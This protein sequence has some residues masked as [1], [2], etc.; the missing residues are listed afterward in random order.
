MRLPLRDPQLHLRFFH[1][2]RHVDPQNL[3]DLPHRRSTAGKGPGG[4]SDDGGTA[5]ARSGDGCRIGN[6]GVGRSNPGLLPRLLDRTCLLNGL[7]AKRPISERVEVAQRAHDRVDVS[8]RVDL[9][10]HRRAPHETARNHLVHVPGT[11]LLDEFGDELELLVGRAAPE[12]LCL[13]DLA[14][15]AEKVEPRRAPMHHLVAPLRQVPKEPTSRQPNGRRVSP[16]LLAG[17]RFGHVDALLARRVRRR[18]PSDLTSTT[19][20]RF[21]LPS[22]M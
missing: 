13:S 4:A 2:G 18:E 14:E 19:T 3:E 22:I 21:R 9:S 11:V 16:L 7:P 5:R 20:D 17:L 12:Q 15:D 8:E 1:A 6:V 10:L